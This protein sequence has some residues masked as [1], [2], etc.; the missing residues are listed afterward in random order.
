MTEDVFSIS[1][2]DFFLVLV[3]NN[4]V[5]ILEDLSFNFSH[6]CFSKE[7]C[8]L[9]KLPEKNTIMKIYPNP[10]DIDHSD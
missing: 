5:L 6:L 2:L 7:K 8:G 1:L 3:H 4:Q 10:T 9:D